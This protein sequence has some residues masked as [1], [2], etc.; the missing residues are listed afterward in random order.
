MKG[1]GELRC[2]HPRTGQRKPFISKAAC[3]GGVA[4]A[5]QAAPG[6]TDPEAGRSQV[7]ATAS[8]TLS[9]P[10]PGWRPGLCLPQWASLSGSCESRLGSGFRKGVPELVTQGVTKGLR[11]G[12]TTL[13]Q[14]L[15]CIG[16][17]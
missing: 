17:L 3:C 8:G 12:V 2:F 5:L 7:A 13:A 1:T 4:L 11:S 9:P 16:P 15:N 14:R 10:H 6:G